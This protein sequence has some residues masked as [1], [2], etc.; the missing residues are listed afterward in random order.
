MSNALLFRLSQLKIPALIVVVV[1]A[2]RL[3]IHAQEAV[4]ETRIVVS[5]SEVTPTPH[6]H[7]DTRP[8]LEHI[9]KEVAGTQITVTKKATVIKLDKQPPVQNNNLQELF[10][11]APGLLVSEQQNPGQ[12][13]YSYRGLGNPQE[14]EYTLFLRDGLPL[15]SEWIG[16]PT[17]YYQPVPQ[18]VSEIQIIRGGSSLL[19]GPEPAPA[20]NFITKRPLP[21]T[22]LSA[23]FEQ[24][25]GGSG[26]YNS[27]GAVQQANGP[28]EFRLDADF[29]HSDGQRDNGQYDLWQANGY[30]G[31]RPDDKQLI[32]LDIHASRFNGGDP[33]KINIFQFDADQD[34]SSTPYNETWVDRYTAV[35]R[36]EAE[37][38]E[39]WLM[40][41]KA[42]YTHQ[43]IDAR[44]GANLGPAT[45]FVNPTVFP[46]STTFGYEAF[47][48]GGV[49]L[50]FRK[51]WGEGTLF[52]GSALT[53]GGVAY[54]GEAPFT[55]Y[56]LNN[57]NT[58]AG[59]L[60]APR[61]TT[62]N[63]PFRPLDQERSADYQALFLEDLIRIGKFHI[64]P[65]F[66]LDHENVEVNSLRAPYLGPSSIGPSQSISADHWVPLWGIGAGNDF[67]KGNETYFSAT[68]GW[69]PTRFFDIAGTTRTISPTLGGIPDPFESIDIELG[70]HGTPIKGLWYDVGLFWM[71]FSNRTE[72]QNVSTI[73][74]VIVNTGNTR[75]RGLEAEFSYDLLASFH[76]DIASATT[77]D[78][79]SSSKDGAVVAPISHPLE[80]IVF[81]NIQLLD[82]EFTESTQIVPA[83]G[84][85]FVGNE[86]AYA[87]DWIWKGGITFQKEKCFRVTLSGIHVS[88]QF[89]AD[90]NQPLITAGVIA[91]PAIIPSYTVWNLSSEWHLTKNLRLIAG[92]SNLADEKYYSRAF[93]TGLIDPAPRRS[94]YAGLSVE[95]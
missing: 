62:A 81:S 24:T 44:S 36:Y 40:Q 37:F 49:D 58:G 46:T 19:Y 75:H 11:K 45:V 89:W 64:V 4:A 63:D 15:M 92:V 83:T 85:S 57:A 41:A 35:L 6:P 12:F 17:L 82:A 65:S 31:Y 94:A 9:M 1:L 52:R 50:R 77:A 59:F 23:Y 27:Y 76:Q 47:D 34:F 74:F 87:P 21:G 71:E 16:F 95:F 48:N 22:P 43:D 33:G 30:F 67:G 90:S 3:S 88:E 61:G 13:N 54:H 91:V 72:S 84:K 68:S 70:V 38:A 28:L 29:Q 93:L 86:P 69:R 66:R 18:S 14:A 73:D 2:G 7:D 10:T 78:S 39:N 32:A 20:V 55:R 53:F 56:T 80:L 51:R 60:Y 26:F 25:G 79:K 42:W 5:A 8:K